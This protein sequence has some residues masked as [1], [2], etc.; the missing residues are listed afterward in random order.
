M[1]DTSELL[2]TL[3][4]RQRVPADFGDFALRS[5]NLDAV[6][7]EACRLVAEALGTGRAKV[8]EIERREGEEGESLLV[9]A[10]VGWA[11]GVVGHLRLPMGEHSSESYSIRAGEPVISQDIA[12]EERFEVPPFMKDAGVVALAN[13]PVFLPGRKV[14]GL[15]QV[16]DTK[17]RDF[18]QQDTEFLR[19]YATILGPVIDRLFK[20]RELRSTQE[21]F[22]LTVEAATDYAILVTDAEGRI[23]D[24]LPGAA[25]VFGWS[26]EEIMGQPVS[27]LFTP[28]DRAAGE[29][30]KEIETARREGR[31]PNVRWHQRRDGSRVFI[32]GSV[33]ALHDMQG[34][35]SGFLKV[36]QDVTERRAAAERLRE[37]EARFRQFAEASSD[38][39]WIRNAD[40][41]LYEYVS[42]AFEAIYGADLADLLARNDLRRWAELIHPDDRERALDNLRRARGGE[43]VTHD[44]RVRRPDGEERW[45]RDTDFPLLDEEGRVERVAGIGQDVTELKRA[46][47]ALAESEV[48]LRVLTEGIPQL[49]WRAVDGGEWTWS[50]SQ[51][52]AYTGLSEEASRGHGWLGAL[53]PDDR[54]RAMAAWRDAKATGVLDVEYRLRRTSDGAL[55]WFATRASAV[56][57]PA[58]GA[59]LEWLGTSTDVQALKEFQARQA[60]LVAELQHRTR[61]LMAVVR[62]ITDR[63]LRDSES[64]EEF[65]AA[66]QDRLDALARVQGLLS[67]LHEDDRLAFDELIRA[68]LSALSVLDRA[69]RGGPR[70]ALEGPEGV[71]LRSGT[72]QTLA[73]ALHE[74]ATNAV[75]HGAF[76][77]AG[78][79]LTV[80]WRLVE[81]GEG[82]RLRVEWI[83]RGVDMGRAP[84]EPPGSG[85][86]RELIERALPYQLQARTIYALEP[87]GVRCVIELPVSEHVPVEGDHA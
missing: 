23:T 69:G 3:L 83:E 77:Q 67:R 9:R 43:Q 42:P 51:W 79:R 41:L 44:F 21:R 4:R 60:V 64:P 25:A 29:D 84:A 81:D 59:V 32:E 72:V 10:G 34:A 12:R 39:I 53:H 54:E 52:S 33:R 7:H 46:G 71:R 65:A 8:L 19:T 63:T 73:L 80:R 24:W 2:E 11:P 26:A 36:G 30:R 15:L 17:P 22:R 49:V 56:R 62:A 87:Q 27:V 16:D 47:A 58:T 76:T 50:S 85:Y 86:G 57:D 38:V 31:A 55:R 37:S 74:L 70:V 20:L 35:P 45:V 68:E 78:G 5:E 48:R 66:F 75:K 1:P 40:T 28:E 6:L 13:V 61:N 82:P 18:D 14:Y